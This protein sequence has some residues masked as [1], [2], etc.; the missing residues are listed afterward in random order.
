MIILD[1]NTFHGDSALALLRHGVGVGRREAL[2][3]RQ[4]MGEISFPGNCA[5]CSR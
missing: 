3:P 4:A 1:L 2:P 5:L